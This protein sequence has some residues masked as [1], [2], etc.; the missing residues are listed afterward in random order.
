MKIKLAISLITASVIISAG[1]ALAADGKSLFE[2]N[3]AKC[4]GAEGKGDTKM[5]MR[6]GCKD[7]TDAKYQ[8][9]LTDEKMADA[10]KNGI[11]EGDKTKMK[12]FGDVLS[13][14]DIKALVAYVRSFKK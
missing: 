12:S 2:T 14:D 10:I 3:C 13:A 1:S 7:F 4:H 5:G 6:A 9:G 8:A 11:K